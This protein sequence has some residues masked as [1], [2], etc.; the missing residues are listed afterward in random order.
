MKNNI[1]HTLKCSFALLL[2]SG[3]F[4]ANIHAQQQAGAFKTAARYDLRGNVT[5]TI[6]PDPDGAGP[7]KHLA[8]RNTYNARGLLTKVE[9]GELSSWLNDTIKPKD[10]TS[11][12]SFNVF[13]SKEFEY[14]TYG[15]KTIEAV[16][17]K[18]GA[19]ESLVQ[20]NYDTKSRVNCKALRMNP[21]VYSTG[22]Y[23][24]LPDACTLG[25]QGSF[26]PD[27]I[28]QFS[29]DDYDQVLTETRALGVISPLRLEQ[30]YVRNEYYPGSRKLKSQTDANGNK[31][32][33]RYDTSWRLEKRVYPS[34]TIAG[35]LNE[36]DYNQ[37]TY[38]ANN[39]I[40]TERK[41]D[42]SLITFTYDNNN[43][44]TLKDLSSNT[45]SQDTYYNYDLRGL[46]LH[47][48]FT[49]DSGQGVINQFDGFGRVLNTT[50]TMGGVN[51]L[52]AYQYDNNGNRTRITH[53]DNNYF[54]Y[55]F[56]G[57]NRVNGVSESLTTNLLTLDYWDNGTRKTINRTGGA[58][59]SYARDNA[60]RLGS[61]TQDFAGTA[62]DLTNTFIYNPVSQV[63]Q[64][65]QSNNLY[66]Y[67]GN[68][69]KTGAYL[70]N[71]LNQY[72]SIN[73]FTVTY[74]NNANLTKDTSES[75]TTYTYDMENRL[76]STTNGV[77]SNFVYDPLGR[78][79][80]TTIGGVVTQFLY[81]GDA[82]VAEYNSSNGLTRR[83]VHGDQVDEPWVE[84]GSSSIGVGYRTYLHAD[85]QGSII[86]RTDG[87]G[88]YRSKLTYDSF[89]IPATT[90]EGRFGYTGQIWFKDLGLFHYKARMYSPKLGRFLQTDP[91][92]YA[93][94]MNMYAYVGNDP[95][96]MIDPSGMSGAC[97]NS[98]A[99]ACYSGPADFANDAAAN[100]AASLAAAGMEDTSKPLAD[101]AGKVADGASEAGNIIEGIATPTP[102]AKVGVAAVIGAKLAKSVKVFGHTFNTHGMKN[103]KSLT[104]R[105]KGTGTPQGQWTD[106]GKAADLLANVKVDGPASI[107]IPDGMGRVIMPDG[108]IINA[109]HAVVVP[110]TF[111]FRTAYPF[112]P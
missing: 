39:N 70:P 10:W 87:F 20:Y 11:Y 31:T 49:S 85:H 44:L 7:L 54:T 77:N 95:V 108:T 48:R 89:G 84:Y 6:A 65:T 63:T 88:V 61:F 52:L 45:Y 28:T 103:T 73:G 111:G 96:N 66:S 29:Y 101:A 32:E 71:G 46:T 56:D 12:A 1:F 93:D 76:V 43:R 109:K 19:V 21:N 9:Q 106:D 75:Q 3:I 5:G 51:R 41:R 99:D 34:K 64:F 107:P 90:N 14:D 91:I 17:G 33:L 37:Y 35:S 60:K 69:N 30:I 2:A 80:Q 25:T 23:T 18:T 13:L 83:Y 8:T 58:K 82:L 38:D 68:V 79:F 78:L 100:R 94:Q 81:D 74:D 102:T 27:R 86:A 47:S 55:T 98:T 4:A 50:M 26:G 36:A 67:A 105:A 42:G 22:S 110:S 16:R 53:P 15:R 57:L 104:D 24:S 62:N 92:F 40:R 97:A 112:I 59:T 72:I